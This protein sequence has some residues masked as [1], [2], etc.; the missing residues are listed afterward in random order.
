[1]IVYSNRRGRCFSPPLQSRQIK[2]SRCAHCSVLIE[3]AYCSIRNMGAHVRSRKEIEQTANCCGAL[4]LF[5]NMHPNSQGN[6]ALL[7]LSEARCSISYQRS[8]AVESHVALCRSAPLRV[9]AVSH[10]CALRPHGFPVLC[11]PGN[12]GNEV[13]SWKVAMFFPARL[14]PSWALWQL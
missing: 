1:M 13:P 12:Q 3:Y 6:E 14:L 2:Q 11:I 7:H 5:N 10:H 4:L 9:E 8:G